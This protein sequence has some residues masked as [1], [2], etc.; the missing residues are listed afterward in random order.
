MNLQNLD[1]E[2]NP[3]PEFRKRQAYKAIFEELIDNWDKVSPLPKEL[4][5]KLNVACPL[6]IK[7]TL[8][9]SKDNKTD[10]ALI[11]LE[12]G[13]KIE[14]VLMRHRDGRNTVC[15]STQIG[16]AVNC[17][18]CATG[19]MG[20]AR[21]LTHFEIVE[22][23]LLFARILKATGEKVANIVF[24]GM[25]EPFLN[26][27]NVFAAIKI[28]N[29]KNLFN[30]G[31][32][33][34]SVSTC[35][36]VEGIAALAEREPQVNLAISLHAP[37]NELRSKLVPLNKEYSIEKI[38]NAV[39][40]YILKTNRKVMFE[41]TLMK[42]VNDSPEQAEQLADLLHGKLCV[43][44]LVPYNPTGKYKSST[45]TKI[46]KFQEVLVNAGIDVSLRHRF[47]E[48]IRAA[49]G[50]LAIGADGQIHNTA[51]PNYR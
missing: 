30:I 8:F 43:V 22:Q 19:Q 35:G 26:A 6:E 32:R 15:V 29:D 17:K 34:I 31:A 41:Y 45:A 47:G 18:F 46:K 20:F 1:N 4:R 49:C 25:G 13:K 44:N 5:D 37:D 50:Q 24:M 21:N 10:K 14:T 48:D 12:D 51:I 3:L 38:I 2:L 39:D 16:C 7:A 33:R 36:I 9:H 42:G 11:E 27:E 40:K 23:V 28:F